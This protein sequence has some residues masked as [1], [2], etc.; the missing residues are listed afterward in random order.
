MKKRALV[1]SGGGAKGAFQLGALQYLQ[2]NGYDKWDV[3]AGVSVGA[4]N[5]AMLAMDKFDEME[6]LW[7]ELSNIAVYKGN[8]GRWSAIKLCFKKILGLKPKA[9][10][11]NQPLWELIKK[12]ISSRDLKVELRI[13]TV[14]LYSGEYCEIKVEPVTK[15]INLT[16]FYTEQ[17][18]G[19][20]KAKAST[21]P[22]KLTEDDFKRTVLASTAIPVFWEP[23]ELQ[24]SA[25]PIMLVDGGVRNIS[26]LN[27]ILEKDIPEEV[28][29]INC[30]P[31]K[32]TVAK[33]SPSDILSI[34]NRSFDLMIN[35]ILRTD[36]REFIRIN[37]VVRQAEAK[38]VKIYKKDGTPYKSFK[39][40]L[41]KPDPTDYFHDTLDFSKVSIAKAMAHGRERAEEAFKQYNVPP[42]HF[43]RLAA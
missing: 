36:I 27:E 21:L 19:T 5:G 23:V 12:N 1:L 9:I 7:G 38:N 39:Y 3:I 42:A 30:S 31:F 28:V 22:M 34:A 16:V 2:E 41:I 33:N 13:G 24:S 6:K 32:P 11:S 4:L 43:L 20:I 40:M 26:P 8:L 35:E 37:D 14:E 25:I 10:L 17:E 29:I 15:E 18:T